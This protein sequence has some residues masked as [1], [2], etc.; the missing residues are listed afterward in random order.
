M[1]SE[2]L[3]LRTDSNLLKKLSTAASKK[4]SKEELQE[5]RASFVFG[6]MSSTSNLTKAQEKKFFIGTRL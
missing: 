2:L 1:N 3:E 5:Q 6:S 4:I